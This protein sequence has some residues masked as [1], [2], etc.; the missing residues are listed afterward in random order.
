M[1]VMIPT[2]LGVICLLVVINSVHAVEINTSYDG[3]SLFRI[4]PQTDTQLQHLLKLNANTSSG[5][6]F[7]LRSTAVNN[8]ADVL[9]APSAKEPLLK[10]LRDLKIT[11]KILIQDVGKLIR[12]DKLAPITV[13]PG[14]EFFGKYQSIEDINAY[15]AH[16]AY[17][18]TKGVYL[19][20]LGYS[21][22]GR[23]LPLIRVTTNPYI[24]KPAIWIQGGAHAREQVGVAVVVYIAQKLSSLC[25]ER[26]EICTL[27][28]AFD[29]YI[30]PVANPDGYEYC[31][32]VDRLWRKT[33]SI[34]PENPECVGVDAN[35]NWDYKWSDAAGSSKDPCSHNYAGPSAFSE[36]ETKSVAQFMLDKLKGRLLLF[37]DFHSYSQRWLTPW[38][39]TSQ[40][41]PNY[42]EQKSLAEVATSAIAKVNGTKYSVGSSGSIL[43]TVSGGARDWVYGVAGARYSNVVEVRDLGD[44]GFVLPRRQI[45]PTVVETW[46]GVRAMGLEL[47]RRLA[48]E[49]LENLRALTAGAQKH[50]VEEYY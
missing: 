19:M 25:E 24:Q 39:Y 48:R 3:Y 22:E 11:F 41:P 12:E 4:T 37:L 26:V 40:L 47:Y 33:R 36:P 9:V 44:F 32:N 21:Y 30:L 38:G 23:P 14:F 31:Q 29:W 50:T 16:I 10:D 27:V 2:G 18:V 35:R 42:D 6:D 15:L 13:P 8:S 43:Y 20:N 46:A 28:D 17:N 34:N 49:E 45:W 7:W 1:S 5:L